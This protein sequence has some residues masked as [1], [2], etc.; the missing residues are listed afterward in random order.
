MKK[1][2]FLAL[3][4]LT[5]AAGG[6]FAQVSVGAGGNLAVG[7]DSFKRSDLESATTTTGGGFYAFLDATYV[8]AD[9]GLL[10]GSR[11]LKGSYETYF[12]RVSWEDDGANVSILT[13]GLYGKYPIDLGGFTLFPILGIQLDVGLSAEDDGVKYESEDVADL[14]NRFWIKFGVGADFNLSEQL[15]L[16]PSILYGINFGTKLGRDFDAESA[17]Y[18]GLDIRVALGFRL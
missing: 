17:F 5:L 8:E 2:I 4:I 12:G 18:H 16:R 15:Y 9:I 6:A 10:F 7:W 3:L 13:L 1:K 11:K 14:L